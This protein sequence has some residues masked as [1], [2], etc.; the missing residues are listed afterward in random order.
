M[1]KPLTFLLAITILTL[2]IT[3]PVLAGKLF[4]KCD[5]TRFG[6]ESWNNITFVKIYPEEGQALLKDQFDDR[7]TGWLLLK[8]NRFE[9]EFIQLTQCKKQD[10][11]TVVDNHYMIDRVTGQM[12][13]GSFIDKDKNGNK[14]FWGMGF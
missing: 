5:G 6:N 11:S 14:K 8:I 4:L 13:S 2:S 7:Y 1:N 3:T 10:C 9:K 12:R